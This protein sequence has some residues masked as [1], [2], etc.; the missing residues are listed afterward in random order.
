MVAWKR[1]IFTFSVA[2]PHF[3]ILLNRPLRMDDSGG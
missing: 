1:L 3:Y 2:V